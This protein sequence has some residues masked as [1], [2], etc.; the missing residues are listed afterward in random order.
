MSVYKI[1]EKILN[2]R[3]NRGYTIKE[4][5]DRTGISTAL[6]SE[7]ER[8]I[9]NPTLTVLDALAKEMG[10][11]VSVL[12]KQE[13]PNRS[14]VRRKSQRSRLSVSGAE[15]LY[16]VLSVSPV[17]SKMEFLM[18]ELQPGMSSNK[19]L[20]VHLYSEEIAYVISGTVVIVFES[21]EICL[22][23]GDTIRIL[24][25]RGHLFENRTDKGAAVIFARGND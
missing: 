1:G 25:G 5:S 22:E 7:L 20:S 23:E 24:P 13:I 11:T 4:F 17:W 9:G 10:I 21:E 15:G 8:D 16:E 19:E 6:I 12:L 3:K 18:L 2:Y 14:L